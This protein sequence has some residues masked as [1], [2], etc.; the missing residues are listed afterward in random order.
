MQKITFK[1]IVFLLSC[2]VAFQVSA[3]ESFPG[4]GNYRIQLLTEGLYPT[5]PSTYNTNKDGNNPD[6]IPLEELADTDNSQIFTFKEAGGFFSFAGE[7]YRT[8][9]I[10]SAQLSPLTYLHL[11]NAEYTGSGSRMTLRELDDPQMPKVEHRTFIVIPRALPDEEGGDTYFQ[12]RSIVTPDDDGS[13]EITGY[14]N[15][16]VYMV[17]TNGRDFVNHAGPYNATS[18]WLL[19]PATVVLSTKTVGF[20][21][22]AISNPVKDQLTIKG[23]SAA[24]KDISVYNL[25]GNQ[26]ITSKVNGKSLVEINLNTL[27]SGVYIVKLSGDNATFSKKIIKE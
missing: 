17:S 21:T 10:A 27:A 22:V 18:R 8:Y 24:I 11:R 12:I 15:N 5:I 13:G 2:F 6:S 7:A 20:E 1:N 23:L 14:N 16:N 9:T 3:Q 19:E 4:E 25:L 26:V